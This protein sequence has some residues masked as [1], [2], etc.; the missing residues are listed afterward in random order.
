MGISIPAQADSGRNN[1]S[2]DKS[3]VQAAQTI[4]QLGAPDQIDKKPSLGISFSHGNVDWLPQLASKA[5]WPDK[6]HKKLAEIIL[7]ESGGCPNRRGGDTVDKNCQVI[8]VAERN[9]RS[10]TGLLQING[11]NYDPTRNK[12]AIA[13]RQMNIC[14]QEPLLDPLVNLQVGYLLYQEAGWG[15]WDPCSWDKTRCPKTKK[16]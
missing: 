7:R 5:G 4:T 16:P 8:G 10:D 13:C 15:P 2:V 6:T 11:V 3:S 12:W 14:T 9:H 1:R